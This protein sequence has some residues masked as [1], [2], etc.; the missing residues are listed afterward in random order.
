[1]SRLW[2]VG[3]LICLG[4]QPALAELPWGDEAPTVAGDVLRVAALGQP[5]HRI[6]AWGARRLSARRRGEARA[7]EALHR[8][9]DD[10]LAEAGAAPHVAQAVHALVD[11]ASVAAVRPLADGSAVV[12]LAIPRGQLRSVAPLEGLPW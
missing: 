2:C 7:R 9:A 8:W 6:H 12:V 10:A 5:D 1:M 3:L 4:A 11:E